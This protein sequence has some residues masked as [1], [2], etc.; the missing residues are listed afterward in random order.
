MFRPLFQHSRHA[1]S[2]LIRRCLSLQE[3]QSKQLLA[4][5]KCTVQRFFVVDSPQS[6]E[7]EFTKYGKWCCYVF[8]LNHRISFEIIDNWTLLSDYEEYA[9][10]SQLLAGGRGKGRFIGGPVNFGGV[11]ITSE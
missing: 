10:K 11:Q 2:L 8:V 5:N 4:E 6:A 1:R 3:Y 9:V 7:N